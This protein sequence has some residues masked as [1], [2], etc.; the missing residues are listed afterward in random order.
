MNLD[1]ALAALSDPT[2]RKL[3][4][5]LASRGPTRAGELA[6]GFS[7]S[8]PGVTKHL[9][10]LVDAGLVDVEKAGRM[11]MYRLSPKGIDPVRKWIA[12][13]SQMWDQALDS[14]KTYAERSEE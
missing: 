10:V 8:R 1:G 5:R 12:E 14:L 4:Q 2:R 13:T 3:V 11:M 7:I 6:N 9:G